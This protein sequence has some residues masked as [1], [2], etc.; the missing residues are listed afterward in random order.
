MVRAAFVLTLEDHLYW[1]DEIAFNNIALGL[2]NGRGYQSDLYRANP[3]LPFF[4][5]LV[6]Q[7]VGHN[8]IV[9]RLIQGLIGSLTVYLMAALTQQLYGRRV[10]F[11]A[12]LCL[13]VFPSLVYICGVFYVECLFTSLIALSIYTLYISSK[14]KGLWSFIL[15]ILCGIMIG[16]TILCRAIFLAFLPFAFLFVMFS[17]KEST[18]RRILYAIALMLMACLTFLPWTFRNYALYGRVVAVSTGSGLFLWK[19]NNELARGDTH[20]RYL[21]PGVGETWTNRLQELAPAHRSELMQKYSAVQRDLD[22]LDEIDQDKYLQRLALTFISEHPA[23]SLILFIRKVGTLYTAFT[24]VR[25]EN[26]SIISMKKRL[27]LSF[28]FYVT[29]T[30]GVAGMLY[31]LR[32]WQQC[33]ILYLP[34]VAL[35]LAYGLLT[36]AARFRIPFEPYMIIFASYSVIVLFDVTRTHVVKI[37]ERVYLQTVRRP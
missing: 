15:L 10:A 17:Y 33:L 26:S 36:S 9:A 28:V 2:L 13:A 21:E 22:T 27:G 1:P 34:I 14:Y 29:L 23:W 7:F 5:A 25:T 35:T 24:E 19:G 3:V 12:G 4:L 18:V 11:I 6:Y 16:V 30:L 8:Y 20:D 31:T 37:F 32:K